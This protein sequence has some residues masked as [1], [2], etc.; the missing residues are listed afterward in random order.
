LSFAARA[1]RI[2]LA[3][4]LAQHGAHGDF[5]LL[6]HIHSPKKIEFSVGTCAD[7]ADKSAL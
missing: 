2:V 7:C 4:T 1:A 3:A 5:L 6:C